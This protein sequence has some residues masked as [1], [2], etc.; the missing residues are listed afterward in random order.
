MPGTP[1]WS[2]S[3]LSVYIPGSYF[4]LLLPGPVWLSHS[5]YFFPLLLVHYFSL[6][7][8]SS[9]LS[10]S[11]SYYLFCTFFVPCLGFH[12]SYFQPFPLIPSLPGVYMSWIFIH[13][14]LP[15]QNLK[16][17]KL[18]YFPNLSLPLC[19][20]P[21]PNTLDKWHHSPHSHGSTKPESSLTTL[22]LSPSP[23]G[24]SA[25][26]HF[27]GSLSQPCH[28]HVSFPFHSH[29]PESYLF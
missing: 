13:L 25:T 10:L 7:S 26:C 1:S 12:T 11:L 6:L 9:Y 16:V 15:T 28:W 14:I 2:I 22:P 8:L 3:H 4:T 29:W 18:Y 5:L 23:T 24:D 27:P 21:A 17:E 20:L 19:H